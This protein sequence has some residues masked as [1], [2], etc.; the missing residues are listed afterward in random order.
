MEDCVSSELGTN[1]F[2][3]Q[4]KP[5]NISSSRKCRPLVTDEWPASLLS[6]HSSDVEKVFLTFDI[7]LRLSRIHT[8]I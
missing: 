7:Q 8:F 1:L 4:F 2:R 6:T 5:D 3:E